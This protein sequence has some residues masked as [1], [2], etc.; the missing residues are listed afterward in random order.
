MALRKHWEIHNLCVALCIRIRSISLLNRRPMLRW[1]LLLSNKYNFIRTRNERKSDDS[2]YL[3]LIL[4]PDTEDR[5]FSVARHAQTL[6][7]AKHTFSVDEHDT[8]ECS[9]HVGCRYIIH[10]QREREPRSICKRI[11]QSQNYI[12]NVLRKFLLYFHSI[13][14]YLIF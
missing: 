11:L 9:Q 12:N 14:F 4:Q 13:L 1:T 7:H 8:C 3:L 5:R 2:C 10:V 6:R